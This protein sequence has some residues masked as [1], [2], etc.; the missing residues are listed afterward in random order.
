M[1]QSTKLRLVKSLLREKFIESS[2]EIA[3]HLQ[4]A[5]IDG[6]A[7]GFRLSLTHFIRLFGQCD[8]P[9]TA[10]PTKASPNH[11]LKYRRT[12]GTF[13]VSRKRVLNI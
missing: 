13:R 4:A 11:G 5:A 6:S 7:N 1:Q 3:V 12:M 2:D 8:F 9:E 10:S